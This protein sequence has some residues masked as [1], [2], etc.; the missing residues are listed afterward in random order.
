MNNQAGGSKVDS[1][2]QAYKK[3]NLK[4]NETTE[5]TLE[6]TGTS[7]KKA[8]E[9]K[10]GS[11]LKSSEKKIKSSVT[12]SLEKGESRYAEPIDDFDKTNE[13]DGP[14]TNNMME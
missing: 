7:E 12:K 9:L 6:E 10:L 11:E 1:P 3:I 14:G 13:E 2:I 8:S 4:F 5:K